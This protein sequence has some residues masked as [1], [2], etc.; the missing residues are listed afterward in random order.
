MKAENREEKISLK[1]EISMLLRELI[2]SKNKS[3]PSN[4]QNKGLDQLKLNNVQCN[5]VELI[6]IRDI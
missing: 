2:N 4:Y 1:D 6:T 5:P 3:S